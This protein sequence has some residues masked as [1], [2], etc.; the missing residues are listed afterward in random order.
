MHGHLKIKSSS[1]SGALPPDPA[2]GNSN[3][4]HMHPYI[5]WMYSAYSSDGVLIFIHTKGHA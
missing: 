4:R 1:A 5:A 2:F 3:P